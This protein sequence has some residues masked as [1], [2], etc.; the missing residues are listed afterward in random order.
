MRFLSLH[1]LMNLLKEA[2]THSH[3]HTHTPRSEEG[4]NNP[5]LLGNRL[6]AGLPHL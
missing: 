3:K 5:V 2:H 6:S 1:C 4:G